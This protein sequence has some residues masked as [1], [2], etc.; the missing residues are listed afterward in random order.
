MTIDSLRITLICALA[1]PA[2]SSKHDDANT[3]AAAEAPAP[4]Q[5][6]AKLAPRPLGDSGYVID[7][8]ENWT[9]DASTTT[10]GLFSLKSPV[11][12]GGYV[13][14]ALSN[15]PASLDD[16]KT[17]SCHGATESAT[18]PAGALFVR[19]AGTP[20]TFDGK[21]I[22]VTLIRADLGAGDGHS[23]EC[24]A[25][26]TSPDGADR[27]AAICKSLRGKTST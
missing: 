19:C 21:P 1:L 25:E 2:C 5:P 12:H 10:K 24:S 9:L 20:G 8:P 27:D 14:V 17:S 22:P 26:D 18:T 7:V 23:V 3:A 11:R 4:A 6:P 15:A 16:F 13:Q